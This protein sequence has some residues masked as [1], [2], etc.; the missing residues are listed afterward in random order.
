MME[1]LLRETS[2]LILDEDS[3]LIHAK[4]PAGGFDSL[5]VKLIVDTYC[6]ACTK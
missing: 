6:G 3:P 2:R 4:Y 5:S 1:E